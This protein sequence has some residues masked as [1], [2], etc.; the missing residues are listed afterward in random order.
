MSSSI[1]HLTTPRDLLVT[2][3]ESYEKQSWNVNRDFIARVLCSPT[4]PRCQINSCSTV[5]TVLLLRRMMGRF[6][7]L[8]YFI[9][10]SVTC[11]RGSSSD[12]NALKP[13]EIV[14]GLRVANL[15]AD[16]NGRVVG[17]KLREIQSGAPI[18]LFEIDTVPQ[19]F[20]W[21]DAPANS[22]GGLAHSLEHLLAGKGTKGRYLNLLKEMRFSQSAAGTTDD[23]NLYS[24]SSGTG[25]DGF[26]EQFNAWLNALYKPDFTDL[27]AE[28]EF[29]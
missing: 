5:S 22:D 7:L 17:A 21:V 27:E 25:L 18:Y 28:R 23:F 14:A 20:M 8:V 4:V 24:F 2:E 13:D 16:S 15:Y 6:L 10:A 12:L 1:A 26:F 9:A 19:V 3:P 11:C 29:Y